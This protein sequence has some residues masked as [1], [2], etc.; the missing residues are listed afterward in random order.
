MTPVYLDT[1]RPDGERVQDLVARM[2]LEEKLSQI[3]FAAPAIPRLGI[4]A[5]NWCGNGFPPVH[6]AG[7]H[8]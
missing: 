1:A 6:C 7:G 2:T 5:Y 4:P 3:C 8:L